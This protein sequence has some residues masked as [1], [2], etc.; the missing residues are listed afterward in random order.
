M[1]CVDKKKGRSNGSFSLRPLS[2]LD[3]FCVRQ[4]VRETPLLILTMCDTLS[5]ASLQISAGALILAQQQDAVYQTA[6]WWS[7]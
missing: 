7:K 4:S 6:S 1:K 2:S 3:S 5:F